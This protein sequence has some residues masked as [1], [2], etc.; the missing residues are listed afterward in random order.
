VVSE[1]NEVVVPDQVRRFLGN[2]LPDYMVPAAFVLL[3]SLPLTANGKVDRKAL[4]APEQVSAECAREFVA[5]RTPVEQAV[6]DI[7]RDLLDVEC[8][9]VHDDFFELGGDSL[10][11]TRSILLI[12]RAFGV[13][14]PVRSLFQHS[15]AATLGT[16]IEEMILDEAD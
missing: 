12:R 15:T 11:G 7:W 9:G 2:K 3:E 4:P 5:P 16:V 10:I 14:L 6:A 13:E 1:P 8:I